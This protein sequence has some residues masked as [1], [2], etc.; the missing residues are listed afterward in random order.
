[1]PGMAKNKESTDGEAY[2]KS[3]A[4]FSFWDSSALLIFYYFA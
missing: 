3:K 2:G 1:M 4:L